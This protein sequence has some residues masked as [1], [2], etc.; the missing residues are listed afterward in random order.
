MKARKAS[1]WRWVCTLKE[2]PDGV[3]PKARLVARGFEEMNTK[4]LSK[5]SPTCASVS[6][7]Y[8]GSDMS[9]EMAP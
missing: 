2:T 4:E 7:N 6:K 5:D 3:A 1:L 9:K 8:Y